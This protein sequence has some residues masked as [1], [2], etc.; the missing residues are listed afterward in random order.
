[1]TQRE[2]ERQGTDEM[3]RQRREMERRA[4]S[5]LWYAVRHG[6]LAAVLFAVPYYGRRERLK[7]KDGMQA[8]GLYKAGIKTLLQHRGVAEPLF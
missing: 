6:A 5:C 8:R 1:M 3:R 4:R 7:F 2:W